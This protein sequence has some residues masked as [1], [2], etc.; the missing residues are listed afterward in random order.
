MPNA[1]LP[2]WGMPRRLTPGQHAEL[3][4]LD[5]QTGES[6][7]VLRIDKII[8]SP[9]WTPDGRW[10]I[11]NSDGE[12]YRIAAD[13]SGAPELIEIGELRANDDHVVSP[14]GSLLY[15]SAF[16]GHIH[17]LPMLGGKPRRITNDPSK[18]SFLHFLHG[19]SPDGATL[20]YVGMD[21]TG[22]EALLNI[23]VIPASGG[24]D[25][26]LTNLSAHDDGPE[27]SADGQW[28][29]F[30]SQRNER[31]PGQSQIY[32]MRLDGTDVQQFVEDGRNNW[33]PHTSPNGKLVAYISYDPDTIG[34]PTECEVSIRIAPTAGG[35]STEAVR[36]YGGG[37][38]INVNSWAPDCRHLA[39]IAF[40]LA[41]S[42][43]LAK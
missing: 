35:P 3:R 30:N 21:P 6:R 40:P 20:A 37:S 17:A 31:K 39:Y 15:V 34:R 22:D 1:P 24:A 7:L 33:Y 26:Q 14:D 32:R 19:I 11:Y 12:L 9:N 18:K 10:L 5:T 16:D 4:T 23:F 8:A 29:Y 25:R 13:G 2:K 38:T 36:L 41:D 42:K 27:F 43:D 28:I